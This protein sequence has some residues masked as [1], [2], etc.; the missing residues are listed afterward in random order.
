[1]LYLNA[2]VLHAPVS[3]TH[4]VTSAIMGVGA[5]KRASA[6]RWGVARN[7]AVAWVLTIPAAAV[8]A[9]LVFWLLEL[10]LL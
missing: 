6:V 2:F 8:V 4:V 9:A 10:V 3:T 7:I 5:T 1:V